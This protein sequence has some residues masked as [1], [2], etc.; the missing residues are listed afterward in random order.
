M[1]FSLKSNME[2]SKSPAPMVLRV[3]TLYFFPP[4]KVTV[5]SFMSKREAKRTTNTCRIRKRC[6]V[7]PGTTSVMPDTATAAADDRNPT[8]LEGASLQQ[9]DLVGLGQVPEAWDLLGKL[10]HFPDS[11]GEA[12]R[13][14][15]P[16]FVA[17]LLWVHV[18]RRVHRTNLVGKK[19]HLPFKM[20]TLRKCLCLICCPLVAKGVT[21]CLVAHKFSWVLG[22]FLFPHFNFYFPLGNSILPI[23]TVYYYTKSFVHSDKWHSKMP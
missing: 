10:N 23:D 2:L 1:S 9:A 8:Y 17:R 4:R 3:S 13:E 19:K 20:Y 12:V 21:Y 16:H 5:R 22:P 14:L 6:Y 15:L 18:S 7:S 11:G